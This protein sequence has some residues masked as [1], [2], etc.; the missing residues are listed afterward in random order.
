MTRTP[1]PP[2]TRTV[3]P[4]ARGEIDAAADLLTRAF[5]EDAP[6]RALLQERGDDERARHRLFRAVLLGGPL[7]NG[8]VDGVRDPDTGRLLGVAVW[9]APGET[10][11]RTAALPEYVRAIGLGGLARALRVS[12]AIDAHRPA[13][14][15][16][17]LKAVGVAP[18][19]TGGGIGRTLLA[20]RLEVVDADGSP[21]YLE[22]SN[23]RTTA[24]YRR[25]GFVPLTRVPWP[26]GAGPLAMWRGGH[27]ESSGADGASQ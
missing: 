8:T 9:S 25:H 12:D 4:V 11:M 19:A 24:L 10:G 2:T 14:P 23:A 5:A 3:T 16:W 13:V 21:A 27:A 22:S 20:S 1:I 7:Q 26:D 18:D 17:Y 15:H 6:T